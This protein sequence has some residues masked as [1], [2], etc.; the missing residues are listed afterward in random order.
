[1]YVLLADRLLVVYG[2]NSSGISLFSDNLPGFYHHIFLLGHRD[3][4]DSEVGDAGIH[5]LDDIRPYHGHPGNRLLADSRGDREGRN[6]DHGGRKNF[7]NHPYL[8]R[9]PDNLREIGFYIEDS[10]LPV[11]QEVELCFF[12]LAGKMEE[13]LQI[14]SHILAQ[15]PQVCRKG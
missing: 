14:C 8:R 15:P 7:D 10:R 9:I 5:L 12:S 2:S 1:M 11:A 6:L 4:A 13:E 3:E